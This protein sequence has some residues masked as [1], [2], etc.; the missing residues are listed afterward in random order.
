M[1]WT[2]LHR[3]KNDVNSKTRKILALFEDTLHSQNLDVPHQ[4]EF[5]N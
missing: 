4:F 3:K 1:T 2:S 5:P